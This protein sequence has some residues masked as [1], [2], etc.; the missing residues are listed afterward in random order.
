MEYT[1]KKV[2]QLSGVSSRTLRYYD[3]IDLLKPTRINSSGYRIYGQ[4]EIDRLQQIL[5]Y[6]NMDMK[7]EKIRQVLDQPDFNHQAALEKHYQELL[8][9]KK[10][11]DLLLLTI[12]QSLHYHKG[13]NQMTDSAKFAAFKQSKLTENEANYGQEIREKYGHASIEAANQNWQN[14]SAVAFKKMTQIEN[15]LFQS[16]KKLLASKNLESSEAQKVYQLHKEWLAYSWPNYSVQA[17]KGLVD[18]YLAD[19]RFADYYTHKVAP[20]ATQWLHDT[21]YR[22]AK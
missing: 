17:H 20:G 5:F 2:A 10:Q 16:L 6:R 3:E 4:R 11:I 19:E 8:Q 14:M 18:M 12:E 21:V 13:E 22:Y 7:L 1:I 9:K 15:D